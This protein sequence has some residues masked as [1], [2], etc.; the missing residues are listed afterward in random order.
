MMHS[1]S[2]KSASVK[3]LSTK[4]FAA[5]DICKLLFTLTSFFLLPLGSSEEIGDRKGHGAWNEN[6]YY[7]CDIKIM[8]YS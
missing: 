5:T 7:V 8:A 2:V 3:K 4:K 1:Y 6:M